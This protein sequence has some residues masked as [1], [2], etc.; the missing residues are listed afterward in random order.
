MQQRNMLSKSG[1][2]KYIKINRIC[3]LGTVGSMYSCV[4]PSLLHFVACGKMACTLSLSFTTLFDRLLI[5][6]YRYRIFNIFFKHLVRKTFSLLL[7][8]F[9]RCSGFAYKHLQSTVFISVSSMFANCRRV[10]VMKP[11]QAIQTD[12][13][14]GLMTARQQACSRLAITCAY[15]TVYYVL[16]TVC[17]T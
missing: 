12:P 4:F 10:V 17:H 16:Q 11:E 13:D 5:P 6:S 1:F 14:I 8:P 15:L 2:Q 9:A 3:R 7:S